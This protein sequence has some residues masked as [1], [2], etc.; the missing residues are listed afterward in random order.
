MKTTAK[1]V[2]IWNYNNKIL[3][4]DKSNSKIEKKTDPKDKYEIIRRNLMEEKNVKK[5]KIKI[6]FKKQIFC[7][8]K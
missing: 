7:G 1:K 6:I 3:R 5:I 2:C 4:E 8:T